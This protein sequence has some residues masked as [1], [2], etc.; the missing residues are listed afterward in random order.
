MNLLQL[1]LHDALCGNISIIFYDYTYDAQTY[2]QR[3]ISYHNPVFQAISNKSRYS[4]S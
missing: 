3:Q 2:L 4:V 1:D